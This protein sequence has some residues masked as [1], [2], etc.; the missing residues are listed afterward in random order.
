MP[1][2]YIERLNEITSGDRERSRLLTTS[3]VLGLAKRFG[4]GLPCAAIQ[5]DSIRTT[6]D[7]L[8]RNFLESGFSSRSMIDK[9]LGRR[10]LSVGSRIALLSYAE[11]KATFAVRLRSREAVVEGLSAVA[12]ED[13]KTDFR[14]S[15]CILAQLYF[16]ATDLAMDARQ[17]FTEIAHLTHD[18]YIKRELLG[19]PLR[20]PED[21]E[22][23][24]F[25]LRP[26]QGPLGFSFESFAWPTQRKGDG[27]IS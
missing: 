24:A 9:L 15:V 12:L 1:I 11:E 4:V 14:D 25:L 26:V 10:H 22:L 27:D 21:R 8:V 19:F 16:A 5:S 17:T 18:G 2:N 13:A 3:E 7:V 6:I 23:G 20:K